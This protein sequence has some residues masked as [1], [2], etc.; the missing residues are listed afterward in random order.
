MKLIN[1]FWIAIAMYSKLPAKAV[2]WNKSNMEYSMCFVSVIG[3]IEGLALVLLWKLFNMAGWE[4]SLFAGIATVMPL[5]ISGGIHMDGY[6]DTMDALRSYRT[7]E[8]RLEILKD[9]HIGAFA[10]IEVGI[11]LILYYS[12]MTQVKSITMAVLAG[13]TYILSRCMGCMMA[14]S[15]K[16]A[17]GEGTLATFIDAANK[18]KVMSVLVVT[19]LACLTAAIFIDYF[20]AIFLI[21]SFFVGGLMLVRNSKKYFGG[22]TG[23]IIGY[24]IEF[25]ELILL[26]A[27]VMGELIW[28]LL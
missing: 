12:L 3:M 27:V 24:S 2:E 11:Y 19:A 6:C 25:M 26:A 16:N 28:N 10:L 9:P 4:Y 8:K 23:D 1:S 5:W 18:I 21:I 15:M 22:V 7:K 13:F 17:R 14:V 20:T